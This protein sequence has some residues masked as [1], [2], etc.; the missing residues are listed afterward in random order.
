MTNR[1]AQYRG[2]KIEV[3][4]NGAGWNVWVHPSKPDLPIMRR[5]SFHTAVA[6]GGKAIAE[7]VQRID[8][9]S[10]WIRDANVAAR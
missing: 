10:Y 9:S 4:R 1:E 6:D 3:R 8:S 5:G 7:A 2:Y